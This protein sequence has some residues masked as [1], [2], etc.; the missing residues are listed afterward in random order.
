MFGA[1][2]NKESSI[3]GSKQGPLF[4]ETTK[5]ASWSSRPANDH[6]P[7]ASSLFDDVSLI[8]ITTKKQLKCKALLGLCVD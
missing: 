4:W 6:H 7:S 5:K 3:L 1:P 8:N 2:H